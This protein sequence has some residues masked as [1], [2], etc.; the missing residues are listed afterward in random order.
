MADMAVTMAGRQK[1][2]QKCVRLV[3]LVE[4]CNCKC[5][6]HGSPISPR[7]ESQRPFLLRSSPTTSFSLYS[8]LPSHFLY[9]PLSPRHVNNYYYKREASGMSMSAEHPIANNLSSNSNAFQDKEN[10]RKMTQTKADQ[11]A[12]TKQ[13]TWLF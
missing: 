8:F 1:W 4:A 2:S 11:E 3:V 10:P 7:P 12:T 13:G 9:F 5:N 6:R